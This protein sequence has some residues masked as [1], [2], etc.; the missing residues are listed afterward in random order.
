MTRE[1]RNPL[2]MLM[3]LMAAQ[4]PH[5]ADMT[6]RR[7]IANAASFGLTVAAASQMTS[8]FATPALAQDVVLPE[9]TSVPDALKGSGTVRYCSYG[10]ALQEAQRKAYLQPFTELTGIEVIESEGPDS[11]KIKAMIDTGNYEYDVCE[12]EAGS[13]LNL[14]GKGDYFEKMDYSLFDKAN[15]DPI[16]LK[17]HY[18]LMLPYAQIIGYRTDAFEKPPAT[19]AD[20]WDTVAFPGPRALQSGS[21]GLSPDLEVAT[22]ASGVKP[23]DV[24][25]ID[26]DVAFASLEK[27]KGEVVKWWEAGAMPAQLLSDDEVVLA[28]AWNGRIDA[29]QK[30]GAPIEIIWQD[31]LMRNDCWCV[32][33]NA[34][35]KVN[36]M[37][38]AA[39][40]SMAAPQARLSALI[41]Y[42]FINK[43]AEALLPPERLKLLPSFS[44]N[45]SKLIDYDDQWWAANN[46]AIHDRWAK[47]I[48]G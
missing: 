25:P 46:D 22:M 33:K 45:R 39:F 41:P 5:V 37:K 35:N 36:A 38:L 20:L 23:A 34:P 3:G 9:I 44:E 1:T 17:E 12:N 31:Q 48:L 40:M 30:A 21:G 24:Y 10:G 15:I 28:T 13:V 18:F 27:I 14:Q 47:F 6:R 4:P 11:A 42:G 19:N 43:G 29:A 32:L 2:Q 8:M 16:Y 26:L 7:F